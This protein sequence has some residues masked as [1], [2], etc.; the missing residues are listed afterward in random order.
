MSNAPDPT[1]GWAKA[2]EETAKASQEAIRASRELGHFILDVLFGCAVQDGSQ[3]DCPIKPGAAEDP[4][5]TIRRSWA[6][7]QCRPSKK[8]VGFRL[9]PPTPVKAACIHAVPSA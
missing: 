4:P 1:G 9:G 2:T 5:S 6:S 7:S 8:R 3:G